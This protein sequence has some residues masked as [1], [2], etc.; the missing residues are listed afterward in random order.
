[1]KKPTLKSLKEQADAMEAEQA[2]KW[3]KS[4]SEEYGDY[5]DDLADNYYKRWLKIRAEEERL[6]KM[7]AMELEAYG[8]GYLYVG[9]IDEAGRGPLAGPVVAAC[10]ILPPGVVIHRLNDSKKLTEQARDELY[11]IIKEKSVSYGIGIVNNRKIDEI[12]IYEATRKAME[13]AVS[14]MKIKPD[15][16]IIDAVRLSL[17]IPQRSVPKADQNSVSVAAASILAKVTRDR[18]MEKL[19]LKYPGYGLAKHKGYG[20]GEHIRAIREKGLSPIH[21]VSFTKNIK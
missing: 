10:V 13:L 17:D 12:N 4:L 11:D 5:V 19:D 8:K 20:T 9:G 1:M 7:S 6:L 18:I 14:H 2:Y 15:F 16:L 21:R 3:L